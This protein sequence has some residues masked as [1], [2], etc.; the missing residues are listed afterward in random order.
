M[1]A[2][3]GDKA[4]CHCEEAPRADAAIRFLFEGRASGGG[5]LCLQRIPGRN[6]QGFGPGPGARRRCGSGGWQDL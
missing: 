3:K 6:N 4:V 1:V 5:I 2:A